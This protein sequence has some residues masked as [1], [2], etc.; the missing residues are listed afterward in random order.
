MEV[1]IDL[2][3]TCATLRLKK[4]FHL[5][6][7]QEPCA[8]VSITL[9]TYSHVLPSVDGEVAARVEDLSS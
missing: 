1:P 7:I 5:K 3:Y 8:T 2:R 9:E 4:D 6:V